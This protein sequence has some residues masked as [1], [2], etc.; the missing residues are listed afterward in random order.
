MFVHPC[1]PKVRPAARASRPPRRTR[2][3]TS[4]RLRLT[5]PPPP[6]PP[7]RRRPGRSCPKKTSTS[8]SP[9]PSGCCR[10][11]WLWQPPARQT[12]RQ[13][14]PPLWGE[15]AR[16]ERARVRPP[17][18]AVRGAALPAAVAGQDRGARSEGDEEARLLRGLRAA[19]TRRWSVWAWCWS[20]W[21]KRA[22]R[23]WT[24]G[25]GESVQECK[26]GGARQA[27]CSSHFL[28]RACG[29]ASCRWNSVCVCVLFWQRA[30]VAPRGAS[31]Q[32]VLCV[33]STGLGRAS[34]TIRIGG[35]RPEEPKDH[36]HPLLL[37]TS[38]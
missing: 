36:K 29:F 8:S 2:P 37:F 19:L 9:P 33:D 38:C 23:V 25:R 22:P 17:T 27:A 34:A 18:A 14:P 12:R 30:H 28:P 16:P 6:P 4:R 10:R 20:V 3:S 13:H 11:A 1:P 7:P 15:G 24:T 32:A 31:K 26:S 35:R 5:P 21:W